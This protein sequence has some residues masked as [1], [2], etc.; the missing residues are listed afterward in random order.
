MTPL[1]KM[2][3]EGMQSACMT[4]D[5]D[6]FT[7]TQFS[8]G[9]DKLHTCFRSLTITNTPEFKKTHFSKLIFDNNKIIESQICTSLTL[10]RA[11]KLW[12]SLVPTSCLREGVKKCV[13]YRVSQK[14][15]NNKH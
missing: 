4:S 1:D 13:R 3:F 15:V 5:T 2:K 9:A 7:C 14:K 10:D 6:T 12:D 8:Y 11:N